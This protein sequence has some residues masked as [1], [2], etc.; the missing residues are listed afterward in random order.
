M[1]SDIQLGHGRIAIIHLEEGNVL[2]LINSQ[3]QDFKLNLKSIKSF[4]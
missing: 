1:L 3:I 4:M 2:I